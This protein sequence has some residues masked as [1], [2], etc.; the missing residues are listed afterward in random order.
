[1]A[2]LKALAL[3]LMALLNTTLAIPSLPLS[4]SSRWILDSTGMRIKL[5]CINWAGHMETHVPEGLHRAAIPTIA[6][7]IAHSGFNCVR[8]TY[9]TDWALNPNETVAA[10]FANAAALASIPDQSPALAAMY[11][12]ATAYNPSFLANNATTTVRDVYA[13]VI[14]ALWAN[15]VMTILDNH[16]S[17]ASWCCDLDDGNGWW[18]TASGYADGGTSRYFDTAAWLEGLE[19]VAAWS[20]MQPGVVGLSLR[21]ELR[22]NVVQLLDFGPW[23]DEIVAAGN[24]VHAANPD[25]LVIV[26]GGLSATDLSAQKTRVLD[27]GGWAGKHVWEFHAYSFTVTFKLDLGLCSV[28]K[29]LYG[30][31]N[32]FVLEQGQDFTAPLILSE[33]GVAMSPGIDGQAG[34]SS[35]DSA[36]LSCLVGYMEGNDAEWALWAVQGSYYIR[37]GTVDYNETWGLFNYEWSDMRNPAFPALLGHM[38]DTTQGP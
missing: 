32:G 9:S 29:D 21:N 26:G 19:A 23:Y 13:E 36:Y 3:S 30:A 22:Q 33:F 27:F 2:F 8:L 38:W 17:R 24:A 25:A 1:M 31:F 20:A 5:R 6:A 12:R 4:T 35:D 37:E 34:L 16:V 11:A 15:S 18:D 14:A 10:A 7:F 28:K